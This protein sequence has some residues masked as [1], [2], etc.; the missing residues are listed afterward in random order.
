MSLSD[1]FLRSSSRTRHVQARL[2][3]TTIV[4]VVGFGACSPERINPPDVLS[5]SEIV[6]T[7]APS[8]LERGLRDTLTAIVI[9]EDGDTVDVPVV[10]RTSDEDIARFE[11]GGVL[12][13]LTAGTVSVRASSLGVQS[14]PVTLAVVWLGPAYI[15]SAAWTAPNARGPG[16]TLPDSVR[17]RVL[18]SDSLPVAS[19]RVAFTI[20]QGGGSA[21][22]ATATTNQFGIAATQWTLG[23]SAGT[24]VISASVVRSDGSPDTLVVDNAQTYT[25]NSYNALT[26]QAGDNQ[27]GQILSELPTAPA[28]RLVDSLGA[29]RAGVPITFTVFANGRVVSPVVSTGSDGVASPGRW[30]LGDI[31]GTQ[32]LE[33]KVEAAKATLRAT[34]TG[35]PILYTPSFVAAGGST[36]CALKS[37]GV[38]DCWGLEFQIGT[39]DTTDIFTPTPIE[40]AQTFASVVGGLS[41]NCGLTSGGEAWCWGRTAFMDTAGGAPVDAPEP[42]RLQSDLAWA[43]F[44]PGFLHNCAITVLE[45]AYCWGANG[46]VPGNGD[47]TGQLGD[48]TSTFRAVPTPVAGGFKFSRVASGANHTCGLT[49]GA[50]FCWGQNAVGQLGDGTSQVRTS[51]TAASGGHAFVEIS[52]GN[53]VSCA[54]TAQPDG[55]VYCWG[56]LSGAPQFVPST[57]SNVP[58]FVSLTVGGGHACALTAAFEA[59]CWGGND[60]GQLGD[61]SRTRRPTPTK[62]AGDLRFTQLSAGLAHTCGITTAGAVACWGRNGFGE[63]GES[64]ITPLRITPRHVVLGVTP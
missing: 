41:H 13:A 38:I 39:G 24:N 48:G 29:P 22:P 57:Y 47:F 7:G 17:V 16:A 34:A 21:A 50:A 31:P 40:T 36:T 63:L 18:N 59:Y 37:S 51:P 14:A 33:A 62:V 6:I 27:T 9:D 23:P 32:L 30:T 56:N 10:W 44:S 20:T 54:L 8:V 5:L 45:V 35:T 2:L 12:T 25:I 42:K 15:D 28:V 61:S 4:T 11:R 55:K 58:S 1:A 49:N 19:A 64:T 3:L 43:R 52:A 53:S 46:V 60:F 26:V